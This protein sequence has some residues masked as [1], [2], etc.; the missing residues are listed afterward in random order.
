[1]KSC[2]VPRSGALALFAFLALAAGLG[3]SVASPQQQS[4][5]QRGVV[6]SSSKKS[7]GGALNT[8]PY[9]ALL[10][11]IQN[12]R[13]LPKL[14]TPVKDAEAIAGVL[15]QQYGFQTRLLKDATRDDITHALNEYRRTLDE[16]ANL[17]V[18]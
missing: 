5:Q 9:Y 17:L 18:Y 11:G 16:N 1:M 6:P 3:T 8:G 2:F 7:A 15:S 12:Y 13:S 10:I 14:S 4:S